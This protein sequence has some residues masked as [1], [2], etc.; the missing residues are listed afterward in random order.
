MIQLKQ[1]K[2]KNIYIDMISE[3]IDRS[4]NSKNS[5]ILII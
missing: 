5:L 2:I 3:L 4:K 1:K